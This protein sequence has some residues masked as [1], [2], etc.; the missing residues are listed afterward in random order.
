MKHE[1]WPV[2]RWKDT[3][4]RGAPL[5]R[6]TAS[7]VCMCYVNV[8]CGFGCVQAMGLCVMGTAATAAAASYRLFW[9]PRSRTVAEGCLEA[10]DYGGT[11]APAVATAAAAGAAEAQAVVLRGSHSD[12]LLEAD[13]LGIFSK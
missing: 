13:P 5:A 11:S 7:Q 12:D 9:R 8:I 1:T 6:A 10:E 2:K 4:A 3:E